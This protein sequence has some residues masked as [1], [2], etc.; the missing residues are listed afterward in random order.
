MLLL[1]LSRLHRHQCLVVMLRSITLLRALLVSPLD[2]PHSFRQVTDMRVSTIYAQLVQRS[3]QFPQ[4][5]PAY[6]PLVRSCFS[7]FLLSPPDNGVGTYRFSPLGPSLRQ[8]CS[9]KACGSC[10]PTNCSLSGVP[11]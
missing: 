4:I 1:T 7:K 6:E 11:M 9:A 2:L 10:G 8:I 5:D 3:F